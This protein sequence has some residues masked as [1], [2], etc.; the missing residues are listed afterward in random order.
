[1]D[2][3]APGER[4]GPTRTN[5]EQSEKQY[6]KPRLVI[7]ARSPAMPSP[8]LTNH[9][10]V[11]G[12]VMFDAYTEPDR[13]SVL[14]LLELNNQLCFSLYS[15]K[16]LFIRR[17]RRTLSAL[18]LTQPQFLVLLVLWEWDR[19]KMRRPTMA[20]LGERLELDSGTLTPLLKRLERRQ[21]LT[22][23]A[24]CVSK[25][26]RHIHL[27]EAGRALRERAA[28]VAI[29]LQR[30]TPLPV[31]EVVELRDN[32]NRLRTVLGEQE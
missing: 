12:E 15:A 2:G 29:V 26:E 9:K 11:D 13:P 10:L 6:T 32:I 8:T 31:A 27:T 23:I 22:R 19:T 20:A 17:H 5:A 18:G 25:R 14:D 21:L 16:R 24:P 7:S 28:E 1:M 3:E 30:E 4:A